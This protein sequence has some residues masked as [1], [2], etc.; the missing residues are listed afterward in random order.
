M[1]HCRDKDSKTTK[2]STKISAVF[3]AGT[4]YPRAKRCGGD[5]VTLLWFR[6]CVR[7]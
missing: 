1:V 5:I 2:I 6:A 4:Y 3:R 7:S